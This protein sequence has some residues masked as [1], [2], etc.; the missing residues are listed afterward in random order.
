MRFPLPQPSRSGSGVAAR[1]RTLP[2]VLLV[3]VLL[4][5]RLMSAHASET[6]EDM[7][8]QNRQA[9]V[10]WS[11]AM[12]L[13]ARQQ[14]D[15]ARPLLENVAAL[16]L[17]DLRLALMADRSG[18]AALEQAVENKAFD[19]PGPQLLAKILAGRRQRQLAEDGWHFAAI[20]RFDYADANFKALADSAPDPVALL[21]LSRYNPARTAILSRLVVHAD[22]GPAAK[23]ILDI[24]GDG[25]HLLSTD[26]REIEVNI[27]RLAGTPRVVYVATNNLRAAGEYAVPH[28]IQ[29]LQN[30]RKRDLHPP[31]LYL[32][33]QIGRP[34]LNPLVIAL[35]MKDDVTKQLLIEALQQIGYKQALPYLARLAAAGSVAP[36]VRNA[37][38]AALTSLA[39]GDAPDPASF[40]V[41]LAEDYYNGID[42]LLP[43]PRSATANVWYFDQGDG[44]LRFTP[45][46]REIFTDLMAMRCAEAALEYA[47]ADAQ[48]ISLWLAANFRRE[49]HLDMNVE[50]ERPS[51][52]ATRDPTRPDGYPR[53]IYFARAAGPF[54]N[55]LVLKRAVADRDPGV[56]LGAIAAL[57]ATAG[58]ADL[59]GRH[60]YQQPLIDALAF[61]SRLVRIK[62]A[63]ALARA[64]PRSDFHGAQ[65][66]VPVLGEALAQTGARTALLVDP[67]S[68]TLNGFQGLLRAAGFEVQSGRSVHA[69]RE[70]ARKAR[71]PGIDLVLLA[72][73]IRSPDLPEAL[74]DLRRDV[75]TAAAPILV[76]A[77]PGQTAAVRRAIRGVRGVES[78]L[79]DILNLGDPDEIQR[80]FSERLAAASAALGMRPLDADLARALAHEAAEV[81]HGLAVSR[82]TVLDAGR[83]EDALVAALEQS[84]EALRIRTAQVLALLPSDSAQRAVAHA[85][86]NAGNARA[87]RIA[88]FESLAHSARLHGNRLDDRTVARVIALAKDEQDLALRTACSQALGA[89]NLKT[90]QASEIIRAQAGG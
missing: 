89:L 61:P 87:Q 12:D 58:D 57:A 5:A 60:D 7:V 17:S 86:L 26:P 23:R 32:L 78:E 37:A 20:G 41:R 79:T 62:A 45:V 54:Y 59:I 24:L 21:E 42:S 81:L 36:N 90:N 34:A 80:R 27:E 18:T 55:H 84:D 2:A 50:S 3:L 1:R 48:A 82:S 52:A 64:L 43:D 67:D 4:S 76:I 46:P 68:N 66:V 39:A 25:E 30:P 47:P 16:N 8:G 14:V 75:Q 40:F 72:S 31:I 63:L 35:E 53:A 56:A 83:A 38:Q 77:K 85:A 13:L 71:A 28:L 19:E 11:R 49:S 10:D 73:D 74:A 44:R 9:W 88:A 6:S 15:P 51:P 69:A 70:R 33:P 22:V 29:Y 65:N